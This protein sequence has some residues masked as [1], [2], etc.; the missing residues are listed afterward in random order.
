MRSSR[1]G[2]TDESEKE[3]DVISRIGKLLAALLVSCVAGFASATPTAIDIFQAPAVPGTSGTAVVQGPCYCQQQ[4][5]FSSVLLLQPGTYDL[6]TVRE[7]WTVA[8]YTPD[9]GPDQPYLYLMFQPVTIS[10][11]WPYGFPPE[12]DYLY[13]DFTLCDQTDTACNARYAGAYED[14][15]LN[16][17][18]QPGENAVQV[19]LV[20]H[21]AYASPVPEPATT[22]LLLA[23]L[24]LIV[25]V[26]GVARR[27]ARAR[28]P[29]RR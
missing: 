18:V 3:K 5:D 2:A 1:H 15:T 14:F 16:V 6:G 17:T 8:N 21:Y 24:A 11:S 13:P 12:P 20:G 10:G 29:A 25:P 27:H 22:A 23:A 4:V 9:G 7:Y 19:G 26:T 28:P